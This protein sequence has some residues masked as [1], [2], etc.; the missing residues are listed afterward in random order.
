MRST[1]RMLCSQVSVTA[2]LTEEVRRYHVHAPSSQRLDLLL[3]LLLQVHGGDHY[4]DQRP[5][6]LRSQQALPGEQEREG[7]G[8]APAEH[9]HR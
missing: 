9:S 1:G 2:F 5:V 7:D 6:P 8:E 3:V 4:L